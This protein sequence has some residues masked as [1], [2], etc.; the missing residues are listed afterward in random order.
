MQVYGAVVDGKVKVLRE[1]VLNGV[2][3]TLGKWFHDSPDDKVHRQLQ[4]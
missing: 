2:G 3:H 1:L 4:L